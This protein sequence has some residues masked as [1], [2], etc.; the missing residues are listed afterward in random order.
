MRHAP[1]QDLCIFL[2]ADATTVVASIITLRNVVYL[3]SQRSAIAVRASR[4][5]WRT[6]LTKLWCRRP[7]L[8]R[9]DRKQSPS[10]A[11][12]SLERWG[13]GTAIRHHRFLRRRGPRS[14]SGQARHLQKLPPQSHLQ[15]QKIKAKRGL[16]FKNGKRH[17][18]FLNVSFSLPGWEVY[19]MQIQGNSISQ[20]AADLGF[21][22]PV[23]EQ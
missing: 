21:L 18:P 10:R 6:A 13:V 23:E 12:R 2:V 16:P 9:E 8:L 20:T 14:Q 5:W 22:T 3:L 1:S 4:T 19:L 17:D 11:P 15:H 7:P